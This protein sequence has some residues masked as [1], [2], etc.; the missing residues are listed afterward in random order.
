MNESITELRWQQSFA[1]RQ[2]LTAWYTVRLAQT[3]DHAYRNVPY[4]RQLWSS[5]G[6]DPSHFSN[7]SNILLFPTT[8]KPA[9]AMQ[10]KTFISELDPPDVIHDTSG[11]S[12]RR[13]AVY[14]N[15]AEERELAS[16][17][18]IRS[19]GAVKPKLVL[20]ILPPPRRL[21]TQLSGL[22]IRGIG[23][24]RLPVL[25][26]YDVNVWSDAVDQVA[27]VV[28]DD[29]FVGR[30]QVRID[31]IHATPPPLL[32]YITQQLISRG[33][34]PARAAI[35]DILLTGGFISNAT[36]QLLSSAWGARIFGSYSCTELK[37][38][39]P[40]CPANPNIFHPS[41]SIFVEVLDPDTL[42]PVPDGSH[43]AL[44]LTGL[45]PYQRVMPMIRYLPGDIAH[46]VE[47][48][49]TCGTSAIGLRLIGR[50]GHV[51]DLS[52]VV[53]FRYFL[54]SNA[55]QDA[56]GDSKHIPVFPYP[57]IFAYRQNDIMG[58]K[59]L[60]VEIEATCPKAMDMPEEEERIRTNL[61]QL[62]PPIH[63]ATIEGKLDLSVKLVEKGTLINYF[64]LYPG[65]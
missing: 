44:A 41:P 46:L 13:L 17:V 14:S 42:L 51:V 50:S 19:I 26:G 21:G 58:R 36:R 25:P 34:N 6:L 48:P 63:S 7:L 3:I 2:L 32:T 27:N 38:D 57:R 28:F 16:L 59:H 18:E 20:R 37:G 23:Q 9:I 35:Q 39:S 30:E 65:R 22:S 8:Q 24:L 33:V 52:D 45:Y 54:G 10:P 49:C 11:T 4:Y 29:Y 40:E 64:R 12:G 60:V 47:G 1:T 43:G 55:L 62:T 53:G 31:L 56:I 15:S 5:M 61:L